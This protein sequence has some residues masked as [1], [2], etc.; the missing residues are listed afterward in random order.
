MHSPHLVVFLCVLGLTAGT[1][2]GQA[3]AD[4]NGDGYADLAVSS[5]YETVAG[6]AGAGAVQIFYGSAFGL[7]L[8][9]N[10]YLS[11][12]ALGLNAEDS[13]Q[14][15]WNLTPGD[16]DGDGYS[17]LA[18]SIH[19][20]GISQ[21]KQGQVAVVYGGS[22]GI[23]MM[24]AQT[25]INTNAGGAGYWD[26]YG[27]S[28]CAGDFNGDGFDE[29]VASAWK[30]DISGVHAAGAVEV[31]YG[32][33][34]GLLNSEVWHQGSPNMPS[35]PESN[36]HFGHKS[37]VGDFDGD[38]IDDLAI[39]CVQDSAFG[40]SECGSVTVMWGTS[41]GGL[42]GAIPTYLTAL[43]DGGPDSNAAFGSNLEVGDFNGDGL[44]DIAI[45][46]SDKYHAGADRGGVEIRYGNP[47]RGAAFF[48][49]DYARPG[50]GYIP[51]L[52][53]NADF[54]SSMTSGDFNADGFDELVIGEPRQHM[55]V[56]GAGVQY[57]GA[58]GVFHGSA[59][60]PFAMTPTPLG[61][62]TPDEADLYG[63]A[64]WADDFNGD[65]AFDL[66]V[67]IPGED[68][69]VGGTYYGG[70]IQYWAGAAAVGLTGGFCA[71][72]FSP[73]VPGP[74]SGGGFGTILPLQ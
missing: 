43:S 54:P 62:C 26:A 23:D 42:S 64:V 7:G 45:G 46:M 27:D 11:Q 68:T 38:G 51:S 32:S 60:G 22:M 13:D 18:I 52:S 72:R 56:G 3:K 57:A 14:F 31:W 34:I 2:F 4:F 36:D 20:K 30:S 47:V 29:L 1:S 58:A 35:T 10:Q 65:G 59:A 63:N 9:G 70:S 53:Q 39:P 25:F 41:R 33:P 37:R 21:D 50:D 17:D 49:F 15:G 74:P 48:A 44:S 8:V 12:N 55:L 73:G 66:I 6:V 24:S 19:Y 69:T 5:Y 71:G 16:F 61:G 67:G 40:Q 28:L